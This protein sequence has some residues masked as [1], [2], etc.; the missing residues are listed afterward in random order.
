MKKLIIYTFIALVFAACGGNTGS[1]E[2]KQKKI[3]E[4]NAKIRK[5]EDKRNKIVAEADTAN[6]DKVYPVRV[7]TMKVDT[8]ED[9]IS[10]SANL[11]PYDEVYLAPASPGRIEKIYVKIGDKV[12]KGDL[13]V[14]MDESQLVQAKLQLSQLETDFERMKILRESNSISQQQ[15]DQIKTQLEV[16]RTSVKFMSENTK[17]VAPFSGIITEKY[18]EDGELYSGAPNTSAGKAF[19]RLKY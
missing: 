19:S 10:F 9:I 4:I 5:L 3:D 6:T 14:K 13:L 2:M 17:L 1:T 8:I 16:T 11:N 7:E 18:F 15:F 12:K